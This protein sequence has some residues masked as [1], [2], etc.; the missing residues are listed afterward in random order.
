MLLDQDYREEDIFFIDDNGKDIQSNGRNFNV[1]S[2]HEIT[3]L[4]SGMPLVIALGDPQKRKLVA[5]ALNEYRVELARIIDR[6]ALIRGEVKVEKGVVVSALSIISDGSTIAANV[7]INSSSVIGHDVVIGENSSISS[8]VNIGGKC[9]I[10]HNV[11]IGSGA[12]VRDGITIGDNAIIS[13]GSVVLQNIQSDVVALGN[14]AK[15]IAANLR[16]SPFKKV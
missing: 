9:K 8:Q 3:T 7:F 10:G 11:F 1:M 13:A 14:P 6:T 2:S 4:P 12:K 15:P 5:L 16:K